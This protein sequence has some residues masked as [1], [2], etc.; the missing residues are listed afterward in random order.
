MVVMY[1]LTVKRLNEFLKSFESLSNEKK[2]ML[3]ETRESCKRIKVIF[4]FKSEKKEISAAM[5][6]N[7][8]TK[9]ANSQLD[10]APRP[11][12]QPTESNGSQKSKP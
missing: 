12:P 3:N 4:K 6:N 8:Q 11:A 10:S 9:G 2:R 7:I 5:E 1:Y